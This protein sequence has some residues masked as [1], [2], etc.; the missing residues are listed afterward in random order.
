M[1]K[2]AITFLV[3]IILPS[4][5]IAVNSANNFGGVGIDGVPQASGQIVVR[6][7]VTGGPAHMA[8]VKV[9][10]IITHIDGKPTERS[11]F[12]D[13]IEHRLRGIEG[14]PVVLKIKRPGTEKTLT[15]H[16][17]RRQLLTP[18]KK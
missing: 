16:L 3:L 2:I 15:F 17:T 4:T 8:G 7:I 10:D 5:V 12:Q 11:D 14:T 13:M 1:L 18:S 6:Q 9:G